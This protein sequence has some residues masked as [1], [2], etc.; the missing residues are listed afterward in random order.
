MF[1][2]SHVHIKARSFRLGLLIVLCFTGHVSL[3]AQSGSK[4]INIA[5]P[6]SVLRTA[7]NDSV[8]VETAIKISRELHRRKHNAKTEYKFADKAIDRGLTIKDTTL[9]ARALDTKGLL[10]R[11]HG[12]YS[13]AIP[14]HIKAYDL[15]KNKKANPKD[16]MIFADNAGVA[17]R[18]NEQYDLAVTYYLKA[19]KLA[20]EKD[21]LKNI[22][23]ASNGMGN[24]LS[25]I[26]GREEEAL[27]YFKTA[28]KTEEKRENS[29]GQAINLL[30]ISD[31]F[32][33]KGNRRKSF[34]NLYRLR[35]INQERKDTFGLAITDEFYGRA[36]A[37]LNKQFAKADNYYLNALD[38]YKAVN[39]PKNVARVWQLLGK[40]QSKLSNYEQAQAYFNASM[41][42]ADSLENITLLKKNAYSISKLK[43]SQGKNAEALAYYKKGKAFEDSLDLADQNEKIAALRNKFDLDK[44]ESQIALLQKDKDLKAEEIKT[45]NEQISKQKTYTIILFAGIITVISFT[46]IQYKNRKAKRK[47]EEELQKNEKQLLKAE[48]EKDL[49]QAEILVSRLQINPHFIFNCLN[50]LKLL[51]QKGDTRTA[52]KYLTTFSRFIRMVLQMPKKNTISLSEELQMINYY[53]KL[54]NKRFS[55]QLQFSVNTCPNSYLDEVEIPPMLLQPFVENAIWHGLLPS[56]KPY[57][58][59]TV[60]IDQNDAT[61]KI[62]I[63]D[64]GVG[65]RKSQ[66]LQTDEQLDKEQKS[67]GMKI[68]KERIHQFNKSFNTAHIDL[69]IIDKPYDKGTCVVLRFKKTKQQIA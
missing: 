34:E 13:Q 17:A 33:E 8:Y 4:A 14:L 62:S 65:R 26:S 35:E 32:I 37:K 67:L 10:Y 60:N 52:S 66:F 45:Q 63:D 21:E 12:Q 18:Y 23:I 55:D 46:I 1:K 7:E 39:K 43:E 16:K 22:S 5:Q 53:L 56:N 25:N 40:N 68:T 3:K 2:I 59:L 57:K 44:K 28:L 42:M 38:G 29:L 20:E 19:L 50:A 48:Y 47:A 49:A 69:N 36:H 11:F 51:I 58:K 61:T 27:E 15:V 54:E 31:Y 6:D 24:A 64:N 30:S 41:K 9:Y